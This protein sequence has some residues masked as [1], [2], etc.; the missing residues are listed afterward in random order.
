MLRDEQGYFLFVDRVGDTF[1]WKGWIIENFGL[2]GD[3]YRASSS[4]STERVN[5]FET[6]LFGI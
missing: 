6:V 3:I 4:G 1:R 5:D 2:Y